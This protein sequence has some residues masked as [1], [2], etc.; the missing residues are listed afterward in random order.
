[1]RKVY[2]IPEIGKPA[3]TWCQHARA[4]RAAGAPGPSEQC[5]RFKL[6]CGARRGR[7]P[8][9]NARAFKVVVTVFPLMEKSMCG[10]FQRANRLAKQP[11]HGQLGLWAKNNLPRAILSSSLSTTMPPGIMPAQGMR[12]GLMKPTDVISVRRNGAIRLRGNLV[13]G[14]I[15]R[16]RDKARGSRGNPCMS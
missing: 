12:F 1:L 7:A 5:A 9:W 8:N 11:Y 4:A 6:A 13:P 16:I 2:T 15:A 10:R 14:E 3:G